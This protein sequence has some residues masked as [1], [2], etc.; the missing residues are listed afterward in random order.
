[1]NK[2]TDNGFIKCDSLECECMGRG[3][4]TA[5]NREFEQL[6]RETVGHG[7]MCPCDSCKKL[8]AL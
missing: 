5:R 2:N 4:R 8:R 6:V 3:H 1:M 7:A